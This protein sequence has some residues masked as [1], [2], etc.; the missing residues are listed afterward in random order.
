MGFQESRPN[1]LNQTV[2]RKRL[3][4]DAGYPRTRCPFSDFFIQPARDQDRRH[5]DAFFPQSV[6]DVEAGHPAVRMHQKRLLRN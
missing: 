4:D 2:C 3:L 1:D 6:D 5:R